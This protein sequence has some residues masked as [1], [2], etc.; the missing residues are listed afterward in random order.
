M[1][2]PKSVARPVLSKFPV[3]LEHES[4]PRFMLHALFTKLFNTA[5]RQGGPIFAFD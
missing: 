1:V 3:Q 2:D 5:V 4:G